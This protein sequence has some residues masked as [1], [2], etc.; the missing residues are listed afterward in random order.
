MMKSNYLHLFQ[1][2]HNHNAARKVIHNSCFQSVALHSWCQIT[3]LTQSYAMSPEFL[4]P[5][6]SLWP[7]QTAAGR[8]APV[9]DVNVYR[10]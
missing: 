8:N 4:A 7:P 1:I 2:L 5:K 6:Y 3:P 9:R 10:T